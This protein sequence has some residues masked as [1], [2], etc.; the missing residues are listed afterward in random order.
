MSIVDSDTEC[1]SDPW[2]QER[3]PLGKLLFVYLWTNTH[4]NI[5]GLYVITK[6]T[7]ADETGLTRKQVDDF[8]RELDPKVKYD[9]LHS[10]CWVVK[11]VRRQFL[12]GKR[13][14]QSRRKGF[15]NM[16]S[17]CDGIR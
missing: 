5:S 4:R 17:S 15:G 12:G 8:L 14:H 16:R 3:S 7:I 2:I 11:H 13:Y 10:V 1:W 6:K 9:P